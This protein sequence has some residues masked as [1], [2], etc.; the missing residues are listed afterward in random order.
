M[1]ENIT[2]RRAR[3]ADFWNAAQEALPS[4]GA[5]HKAGTAEAR[6]DGI[7]RSTITQAEIFH[8]FMHAVW[9]DAINDESGNPKYNEYSDAR[10]VAETMG[11][12][13]VAR[14]DDWN[15]WL[16]P[17]GSTAEISNDGSSINKA[18]P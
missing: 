2:S 8:D 17:D 18:P 1:E 6:E 12:K 7:G 4:L 15:N 16:F 5:E 11:A 13:V 14:V 10:S 9:E 3:P